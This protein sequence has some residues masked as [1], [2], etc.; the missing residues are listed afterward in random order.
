MKLRG[1]ESKWALKELARRHGLPEDLV[2]RPKQGFG[3]PVG[4]WLRGELRPWIEDLILDP[5]TLE[6][7]YLRPDRVRRLLAD[8]LE[9]RADRTYEVWNLAMLELWHRSWI[10]G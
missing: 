1:G 10:D 8:H 5:L 7:G 6:R 9:G 2:T 3:V 4:S